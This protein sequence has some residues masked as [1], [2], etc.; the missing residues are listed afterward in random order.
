M[1]WQPPD[2]PRQVWLPLRQTL[3]NAQPRRPSPLP[4]QLLSPQWMSTR[5]LQRRKRMRRKKTLRRRHPNVVAIGSVKESKQHL[6]SLSPLTWMP[7]K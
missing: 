5:M 3:V 4:R 2:L 7:G 6:P 1:Q